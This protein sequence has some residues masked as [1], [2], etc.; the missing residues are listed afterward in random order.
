MIIAWDTGYDVRS[1]RSHTFLYFYDLNRKG[2][3]KWSD[4]GLDPLGASLHQ[5]ST[6]KEDSVHGTDLEK[7]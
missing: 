6:T 5:V 1:P 3:E 2:I 7:A 4:R